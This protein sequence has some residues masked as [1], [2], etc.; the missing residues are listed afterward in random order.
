LAR[1]VE[2]L[3]KDI[4]V[5]TDEEEEVKRRRITP[6][7]ENPVVR[8]ICPFR[9]PNNKVV[10]V[11]LLQ[12]SDMSLG[13]FARV[14]YYKNNQ[15]AQ[16][17]AAQASGGEEPRPFH[18]LHGCRFGQWDSFP[19]WD[20]LIA[21]GNRIEDDPQKPEVVRRETLEELEESF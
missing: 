8:S 20:D 18:S 7:G 10:L 15:M 2:A 21:P 3:A 12:L 14:F 1:T 16:V 13:I 17:R 9:R 5:R 19:D 6:D 11:E 4:L